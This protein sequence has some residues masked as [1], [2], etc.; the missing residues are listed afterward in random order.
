MASAYKRSDDEIVIAAINA[1]K[2]SMFVPHDKIKVSVD[3]GYLTLIGE[4]EYNYQREKAETAV[5]DLSGVVS[6]VNNIKVKSDIVLIPSDVKDKILQEFERNARIDAAR[7]GVGVSGSKVILSGNVRNFD[8]YREA[9]NA[10]WSV[11]GV[12]EVEDLLEID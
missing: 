1:L 10:A 8:E 12:N 6:V 3:D 9:K 4:V 5:E 2:W 11:P 7:I